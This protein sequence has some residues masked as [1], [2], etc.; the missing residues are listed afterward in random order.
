MKTVK[1]LKILALVPVAGM[2]MG[3]KSCQKPPPEVEKRSYK[4]IVEMGSIQAQP[5]QLPGGASFDFRFVA[6]QQMYGVVT[7]SK[8]FTMRVTPPISGDPSQ[9]ASNNVEDNKYFNLSKADAVL[10]QKSLDANKK[11]VQSVFSRES[12]CMVNL[13]QAKIY[14]AINGFEIVGGNGISIGYS[15]SGVSSSF[16]GEVEFETQYAQLDLSMRAMPPLGSTVLAAANVD[17]KQT[18]KS[19]KFKLSYAGLSGGMSYFYSTPLATVTENGLIM[20]LDAL[21]KQMTDDSWYSRVFADADKAVIL[22][23]GIDVGYK[24]GDQLDVYNEQYAWDGEPCNSNYLG[25]VGTGSSSYY[26][27]VEIVS[28]GDQLSEAKVLQIDPNATQGF[29]SIGA[30]VRL[31]KLKE[32]LDKEKAAVEAKGKAKK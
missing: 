11:N 20:G 3:N 19:T 32:D 2:V 27:R 21:D 30:K 9:S 18:K 12:W 15:P 4:K 16:G 14:G 22:V 10:V 13:P 1:V 31:F 17:S 23:G 5:I 8:K 24:E 26:G 6:N 25:G 7:A 28:V 29:A